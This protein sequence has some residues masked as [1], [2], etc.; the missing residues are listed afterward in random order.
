[1]RRRYAEADEFLAGARTEL[2]ELE[3]NCSYRVGFACRQHLVSD[4]GFC[5]LVSRTFAKGTGGEKRGTLTG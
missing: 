4:G 5:D 2:K 3:K 1:M